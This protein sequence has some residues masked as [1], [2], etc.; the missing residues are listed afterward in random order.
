M[1]VLRPVKLTITNYPEGQ[2][3]TVTVEN[4]PVDPAAGERQVPFSRHLYIEADDFLE[5]PIPKYK[6]LTP[7]GQECRLKGAYL[8]RCTGCVKNEAGEVVEVLCEY[9]PE[10]KGG[11]PADGRKVKG[12]T[13]HWVEAATAAD[14]EVRLYDYLFTDP[15][16]DAADKNFLDYLN[17]DSL[18][19]LTGCKVEQGAGPRR[20]CRKRGKPPL[21]TSSC[22]K[23]TSAWITR[24][25]PRAI[26]C[27]T[28]VSR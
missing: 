5:T 10:S 14:A 15:A 4:N 1:A 2:Q 24:T 26:W 21:P 25:P 16:P 18:Q 8:I 11:N 17:P 22:V 9:D 27:L 7:G 3:E 23:A 6:R 20:P 28:A 12:A 19:V 13:I